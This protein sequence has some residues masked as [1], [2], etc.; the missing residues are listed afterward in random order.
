[1]SNNYKRLRVWG[2]SYT[3]PDYCV[4]PEESFWGLAAKH[5]G[6]GTIVN[7]SWLGCSFSS[8]CHMLVSQAHDWHSDFLLIGI[9]PLERLTV[10]DNFKDTAYN[11]HSID[12]QSWTKTQEKISCHHGLENIPGWQAEKMVVYTDRSWTETQFLSQLFLLTKW[13]DSMNANYLVVNLSK[14]LDSNNVWGPSETV[15]PW[16]LD[17]NRMI[18]FKDTYYS[19]NENVHKPADF[20]KHSWWGHHGPAG[21]KHFFEKSV[22]EKLC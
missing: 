7:Y 16:A 13:L 5:L 21:N 8:I 1:M 4:T 18:L 14:P 2:D 11:S 17:H 15:L 19:V 3:T 22:K 10:F 12:T 20:D 6:V 9:P